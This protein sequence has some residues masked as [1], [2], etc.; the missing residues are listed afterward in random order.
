M[1]EPRGGLTVNGGTV[2]ALGTA[3]TSALVPYTSTTWTFGGT[4]L[5]T[6]AAKVQLNYAGATFQVA[7][8]VTGTDATITSVISGSNGFTKTGTGTLR[9]AGANTLTGAIS[10]AAGT[11]EYTGSSTGTGA[12]TVLDGA[13]LAG[14][15]TTAGPLVLG[16]STG[17]NIL[18]DTSTPTAAYTATNITLNGVTG[19]K[20]AT[21]PVAGTYTLLN[22]TGT[23]SGTTS[24]LSVPYR[25]AVL[26]MGSGTNDAITLTLG[27][28]Y[29]PLVWNNASS[30]SVWNLAS[31]VNW[32]NSG[33]NDAFFNGDTV[34]FDDSPGTSQAI[35]VSGSVVPGSITFSNSTVDYSFTGGDITGTT[36]VVKHDNGL[37]TFSTANTYSGGTVLNDGRVRIGNA[38]ALGSGAITLAGGALSTSGTS[39]IPVANATSVGGNSTLGNATDNGALSLS[40]TMALTA[41]SQ[42]TTDH[43]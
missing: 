39:A 28:P 9:L 22:Y 15:A 30:S 33:T 27:S 25:G 17:A 37:V 18:P 38:T 8:G 42:L 14:E 6:I 2:S 7:D 34:T 31:A 16:T 19:V 10:V 35:T 5:S 3:G 36:P 32:N 26:N 41:A 29:L 1:V 40:G 23:L 20:F 4:A 13:F 43:P 21:L 12:V 24:N 11:L